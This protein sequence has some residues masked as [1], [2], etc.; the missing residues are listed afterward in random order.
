MLGR[1]IFV[2]MNVDIQFLYLTQP[3]DGSIIPNGL[4]ERVWRSDALLSRSFSLDGVS[5]YVLSPINLLQEKEVYEQ[6]ELLY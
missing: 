4:C 2:K 6:A 3:I 1:Q 5:A